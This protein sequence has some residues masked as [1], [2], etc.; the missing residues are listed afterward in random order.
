MSDVK[1]S[2][3]GVLASAALLC[4]GVALG[5]DAPVP[6][7][8]H[9]AP[10]SPGQGVHEGPSERRQAAGASSELQSAL[11]EGMATMHRTPM[12]GDPD[13][14]FATIMEQHHAH[15]VQIARTYLRSAKDA[16]LRA[17]AQKAIAAQ[18]RELAELRAFGKS[19]AGAKPL[20][21]P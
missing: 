19:A 21:G 12:T 14:D 10:E 18:E 6:Q 8:Q 7:A 5:A 4:A 15:G 17:W 3:V 13:R 9:G 20:R 11:M 2:R 1:R 16:R